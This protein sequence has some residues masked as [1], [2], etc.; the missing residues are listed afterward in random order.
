MLTLAAIKRRLVP[1]VIVTMTYHKHFESVLVVRGNT[2][3]TVLKDRSPVGI[4]REVV[5]RQSNGIAFRNKDMAISWLYWPKASQ[6]RGDG[7][8]SFTILDEDGSPFM[9]YTIFTASEPSVNPR[10]E[11]EA[12]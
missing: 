5:A 9:S 3:N 10:T 2:G 12:K 1:G 7:P 8:D 4:P 6:V 11:T